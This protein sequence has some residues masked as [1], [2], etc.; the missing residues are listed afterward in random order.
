MIK[1]IPL[2]ENQKFRTPRAESINCDHRPECS[3]AKKKL[4]R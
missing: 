2:V 1:L 4:K 3:R